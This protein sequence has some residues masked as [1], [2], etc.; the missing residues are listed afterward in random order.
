MRVPDRNKGGISLPDTLL[1]LAVGGLFVGGLTEM[2]T[3]IGQRTM[4]QAE[5]RVVSAAA[6]GSLVAGERHVAAAIAAAETA[7]GAVLLDPDSLR[8]EGALDSGSPE[9]TPGGHGL[10]H[11]HYA[12]DSNTLLALAWADGTL[13]GGGAVLPATGISRT[14][15]L[16]GADAACTAGNICGPGF[17]Q[18]VATMLVA[19][20]G[21]GPPAGAV[22]AVRMASLLAVDDILLR[23]SAVAG[24]P[25]LNRM[26]E[27]LSVTGSLVNVAGLEAAESELRVP[28]GGL[29]HTSGRFTAGDVLEAGR[30]DLHGEL[31]VGG[32]LDVTG[33]VAGAGYVRTAAGRFGDVTAPDAALEILGNADFGGA[34]AVGM[35]AARSGGAAAGETGLLEA[36]ELI[37]TTAT[38]PWLEVGNIEIDAGGEVTG[39]TLVVGEFRS[40]ADGS[41]NEVTGGFRSRGT[42]N[43]GGLPETA[44]RHRER[45]STVRR[46]RS[47]RRRLRG[48]SM[49][50]SVLFLAL[51][52][53]AS[54][55]GTV[56]ATDLIRSLAGQSEA[57]SLSD[58]ADAVRTHAA[59]NPIR[60]LGVDRGGYGQPCPLRC[61]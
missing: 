43:V 25:E 21:D 40:R 48:L 35:T 47:A 52:S 3:R 4:V 54:T 16:G 11:A 7:G 14:G 30:Y 20:G 2:V 22:I 45:C 53:S 42:L 6:D 51:F 32:D 17:R 18:D 27:E 24:R 36:G 19:L 28:D 15:R 44:V 59:D 33:S 41:S 58:L 23:G 10:I 46:H 37:A 12:P 5:A 39:T 55:L 31:T 50:E 34:L 60:L 1:A 49:T 13:P 38:A 8:A 26:V 9:R 61:S 57:R 56:F 29:V